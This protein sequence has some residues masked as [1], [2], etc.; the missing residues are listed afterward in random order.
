MAGLFCAVAALLFATAPKQTPAPPAPS[1][2]LHRWI[3]FQSGTLETR[4]RYIESTAG[5]TVANQQQ[6]K[7]AFKGALKLDAAGNYTI[8]STLGTGNTFAGS[9]DPT[10]IGTGEPRWDFRVR[11]LYAQAVPLTGIEVSAGS[12]DVL[13]GETTEIIGYDNDAYIE[14]YRASVKRPATFYLDEVSVTMAYVGDVNQSNVFDR[15]GRMG[16]HNY[17]QV[18][19]EKRLTR[20]KDVIALSVDWSALDG[21]DTLRQGTRLTSAALRLVNSVRFEHYWR[22]TGDRAYGFAVFA[23]RA[24]THRLTAG[25]GFSHTDRN[26]PPYNG[27]R[28]GRGKRLL[29]E[30]RLALRP[31]LT[32][33]VFY[34]SGV[35]NEFPIVGNR[36]FDLV[37]AYNVLKA[38]QLAGRW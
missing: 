9:W 8:Q 13:R 38:L 17:S 31:E 19:A 32:L 3:D 1:R 23:D 16:D 2:G 25:G 10:G 5:E 30:A 35:A 29:G 15:F 20:A 22:I 4:Y 24:I 11:R 36:R 33:A 18:L 7:Q 21:V 37:L 27:D 6:H 34:T 26:F 28:Y 12:F 14:G